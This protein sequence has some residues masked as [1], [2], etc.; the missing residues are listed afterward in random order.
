MV[1]AQQ[2][3]KGKITDKNTGFPLPYVNIGIV[4][5]GIGTVSNESGVFHLKLNPDD[6]TERDTLVF[7]SI[8]YTSIRTAVPDL[9]FTFNDYPKFIM[10]PEI[11][12]LRE[13]VVT[14][15]GAFEIEDIVGYQNS[16]EKMFGYW[17]DNIALG[18][19]LATKIKVKKGLRNTSH[20]NF[21][22]YST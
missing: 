22:T 14:D 15:S 9:D 19:E 20:R 3:Y 16:G 2:D 7:S 8:G 11:M 18:G 13:V 5:K 1:C 21:F 4:N 12:E 17:K 10:M 6:F